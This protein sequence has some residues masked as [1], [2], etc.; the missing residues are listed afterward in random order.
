[1][2]STTGQNPARGLRARSA[3]RQAAA[4]CLLL[5]A[6]C[7][8]SAP[9]NPRNAA[10]RF[11]KAL[12]A[13]DEKTAVDLLSPS[14]REASQLAGGPAQL[15]TQLRRRIQHGALLDSSEQEIRGQTAIVR[16]RLAYSPAELAKRSI[17]PTL[18]GPSNS[19][20]ITTRDLLRAA[21]MQPQH[22]GAPQTACDLVRFEFEVT[23]EF[24]EKWLRNQPELPEQ[25]AEEFRKLYTHCTDTV[26]RTGPPLFSGE[27]D[28]A[29]RDLRSFARTRMLEAAAYSALTRQ[30]P[31]DHRTGKYTEA[32]LVKLFR[33]RDGW[34]V[35]DFNDQMTTE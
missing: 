3:L 29:F 9:Q 8:Q 21:S 1:M 17:H 2:P 27:S 30:L 12:L 16:V 4:L 10:E 22:P 18:F 25:T 11:V 32:F 33:E 6:G 23:P 24:L 19:V 13:G 35:A 5:L 14:L 20:T 31:V 15:A 7:V 26:R 34:K 28:K